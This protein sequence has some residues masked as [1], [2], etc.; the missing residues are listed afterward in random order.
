[1]CGLLTAVLPFLEPE[2]R[3]VGAPLAVDEAS[4]RSHA[5]SLRAMGEQLEGLLLD[6]G[7]WA[8]A[9]LDKRAPSC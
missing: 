3:A 4:G 6:P 5:V 2:S 1:M 8:R 9:E 7:T